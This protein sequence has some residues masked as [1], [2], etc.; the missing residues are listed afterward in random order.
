MALEELVQLCHKL[1]TKQQYL[2][3]AQLHAA[4]TATCVQV[5]NGQQ[6]VSDGPYVETKVQ[7]GGYFLIDVKDRE[8]A[9]AIVAQIPGS[10]CGTTEIRPVIEVFNLPDL[11]PSPQQ[12]QQ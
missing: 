11:L 9:I 5:R 8:A 10:R 4:K 6:I 12:T 1:P 3:A 7:L 2:G